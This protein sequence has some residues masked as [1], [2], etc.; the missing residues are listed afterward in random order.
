[1]NGLPVRHAWD[2]S[3][4]EARK[5]QVRLA[6]FVRVRRFRGRIRLLGGFD[7]AY[8]PE[9]GLA[10]GAAVVWDAQRAELV[11]R[12]GAAVQVSFPYVPGLLTFREAP[13]LLAARERLT[14]SPAVWLCDGQG[15][16][17]PLGMGLASH[18]G[19]WLDAPTVG[20][21]KTRLTGTYRAVGS[22]AGDQTGLYDRGRKVGAV[23]RT[24]PGV[25]PV[26]VSP[27]HRMDIA[28]AVRIVLAAGGGFRQPEPLR[29]AHI[30]ANRLRWAV[31]NR[32]DESLPGLKLVFEDI[33]RLLGL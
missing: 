16:A 22:R 13:A 14:V 33:H 5:L 1:M 29:R 6:P 28:G 3:P 12:A 24:R 19:L 30:W 10:L 15:R 8:L 2:V 4:S 17:H 26:F 9:W 11:D 27:G 25:K 32:S 31:R 7:V 21:A 23:V 18:L 20:C